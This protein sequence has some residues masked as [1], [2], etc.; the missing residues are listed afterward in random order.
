MDGWWL[1]LSEGIFI[2]LPIDF[3]TTMIHFIIANDNR[4]RLMDSVDMISMPSIKIFRN[5]WDSQFRRWFLAIALIRSKLALE[6]HFQRAHK[7]PNI[8][9]HWINLGIN[10]NKSSK[11]AFGHLSLCFRNI[12]F[13]VAIEIRTKKMSKN[14]FWDCILF[15]RKISF[16]SLNDFKMTLS[17]IFHISRSLARHH[18]EQ[19]LYAA[20]VDSIRHP[21]ELQA[22]N[23]VVEFVSLWISSQ[24]VQTSPTLLWWDIR[25]Q[26][27]ERLELSD[28]CASYNCH[29][30]KIDEHD[31]QE[32][33]VLS[34]SHVMLS[35]WFSS[36]NF[37]YSTFTRFNLN[38]G[39]NSRVAKLDYSKL[40]FGIVLD[41]I[42][43]Y[44]WVHR[45]SQL[46]WR[47]MQATWQLKRGNV[48]NYLFFCK[49]SPKSR[50]SINSKK[51]NMQQPQSKS[52]WHVPG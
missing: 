24:S 20:A 51:L 10:L 31:E 47:N 13:E 17:L 21:F 32:T 6:A 3:G 44:K 22:V 38:D 11:I 16:Q 9:K 7:K 12:P 36:P 46:R 19:L 37:V 2:R 29:V 49:W 40:Q 34:A 35:V 26:L 42:Q 50:T 1:M 45:R 23:D 33:E 14:R 30:V 15:T 52:Q 18:L 48:R 25:V 27:L 4:L 5:S 39:N 8:W 43:I 28:R 41:F